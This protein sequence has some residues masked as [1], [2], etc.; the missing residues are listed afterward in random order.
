MGAPGAIAIS[1]MVS[2]PI[3]VDALAANGA[4]SIEAASNKPRS[5]YLIAISPARARN[6]SAA[7]TG[8]AG[9]GAEGS[10]KL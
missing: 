3:C 8:V 6:H 2:A 5:L 7:V 9:Y 4:A 10:V 1:S